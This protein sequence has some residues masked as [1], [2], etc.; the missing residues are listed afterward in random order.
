MRAP[1]P[2]L[3]FLGGSLGGRWLYVSVML[4]YEFCDKYLS[5]KCLV[6]LLERLSDRIENIGTFTADLCAH[7]VGCHAAPVRGNDVLDEGPNGRFNIAS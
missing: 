5:S 3:S 6:A 2:P 7:R 1:D 4:G